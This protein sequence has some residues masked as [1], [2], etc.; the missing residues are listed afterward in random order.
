MGVLILGKTGA[1]LDRE[2]QRIDLE[3]LDEWEARGWQVC[4]DASGVIVATPYQGDR[5]SVLV[6]R[7]MGDE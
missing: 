5:S 6:W 3:E 2:Y 4:R 1:S 7:E